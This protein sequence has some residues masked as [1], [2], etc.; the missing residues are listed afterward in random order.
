MTSREALQ[1]I[2]QVAK[3]L[4][5]AHSAGIVHRDL[6]PS[7]V[8]VEPDGKVKILDFGIARELGTKHGPEGESAD[9]GTL[10]YMAPERWAGEQGD[11]R[12]DVWSL[13]VMLFEMLTGRQ[14]FSAAPQGVKRDAV[15]DW[16]GL[17]PDT[18]ALIR[19][20]VYRCLQRGPSSRLIDARA[21]QACINAVLASLLLPLVVSIVKRWSIG[22]ILIRERRWFLLH[23]PR[24]PRLIL[25]RHC[26]VY[27]VRIEPTNG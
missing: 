22:N 20:L 14:P 2:A 5:A 24:P 21:V 26:G 7:N 19:L 8:L 1:V 11:E 4:A 9:L 12:S 23:G 27:R 16:S 25:A 15:V 13:G 6:K 18:P 10:A 17:P 3:G